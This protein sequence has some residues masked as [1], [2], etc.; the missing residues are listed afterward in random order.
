VP[1]HT[2][3]ELT[4]DADRTMGEAEPRSPPAFCGCWGGFGE[5]F[6]WSAGRARGGRSCP[7]TPT[8]PTH[9][10]LQQ[11]QIETH[12]QVGHTPLYSCQ[13]LAL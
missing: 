11:L 6:K 4:V 2:A 13:T 5:R 9:N 10:P 8:T 7:E 3:A 12:R 1:H